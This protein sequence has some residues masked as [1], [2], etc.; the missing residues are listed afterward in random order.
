MARKVGEYQ[1]RNHQLRIRDNYSEIYHG[2]PDGSHEH[3][4]EFGW[5]RFSIGRGFGFALF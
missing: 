5:I 3:H 4:L 1:G 2:K